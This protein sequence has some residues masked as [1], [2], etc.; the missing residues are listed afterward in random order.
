VTD[1]VTAGY[2]Y[3]IYVSGSLIYIADGPGG[4]VILE[5]LEDTFIERTYKPSKYALYQ[6]YP[7]PFNPKTIINY[8][9]PIT[10]YVD[11]SVYNLL[12]QKVATLVSERQPAGYHEVEFN[13]QNLSSGVYLYKIE[14]GGCTDVKKMILL[15]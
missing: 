12:G 13:G 14:A 1:Y 10:N 5:L 4:L 7:N 8:E 11:L 3:D 9:L 6:N 2:A 15:R